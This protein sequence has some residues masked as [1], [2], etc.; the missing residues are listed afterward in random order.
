MIIDAYNHILPKKY[1]DTI[2]K[3]VTGRDTSVPSTIWS[4]TV[5]TLIDLDAR[6]RIMDEFQDYI[7]V[8]SV[9]APPIY[10]IAQPPLAIELARIANDELA[11][12]V[13]KYP[14]RFAGGIAT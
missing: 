2:D 5:H 11:E 9:A 7:Q 3:K 12:L 6:F 4:K 10:T 14:S 1:Q 13:Q 8:I